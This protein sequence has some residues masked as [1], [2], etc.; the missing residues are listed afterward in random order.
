MQTEIMN[1][2]P[3]RRKAN[4]LIVDDE[5]PNRHLLET[6]LKAEG[7]LT[8]A[9]ATG[10]IALAMVANM[11]PDLILLDVMMPGMDGF[12][13]AGKLKAD[14]ATEHIPVIMVTSLDDRGAML[15]GLKAG[16]EEFLT[17]P[18]D[19]TALKVRVRNILRL[20]EYNDIL[21]HYSKTL[22]QQV[23]E[24]T[25]R[26][27][28]GYI[29]TIFALTRAAEYKDEDTTAHVRRIGNYAKSLAEALGMDS[30]FVESIYYASPMH[31][32]GKIGIADSIL[33]KRGEHTREEIATLKMHCTIGWE[34]LSAA[35]SPYMQMGAEIALG[36]HERWDGSGYPEGLKEDAIPVS[37]RI[38]GIM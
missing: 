15:A 31:D 6:L 29:E 20:K 38:V 28:D 36:H 13:V 23:S 25:M 16:A 32:I 1:P 4:I 30:E 12:Q 11:Q 24:R 18:L 33:L 34:I 17:K 35:Q 19:R 22:E 37:A 27:R 21:S 26:V 2:A 10:E 5:E 9:A 8:Q 14:P 7:Y 3:A